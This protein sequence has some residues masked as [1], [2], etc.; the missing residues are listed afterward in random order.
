MATAGITTSLKKLMLNLLESS[1][2]SDQYYIAL[3]RS[4]SLDNLINTESSTLSEQRQ[5]RN[6]LHSVKVL[7]KSSMVVPTIEWQA[8]TAYTAFDDNN[9]ALTN[10]Y[11]VNSNREVFVCIQVSKNDDGTI[12]NSTIEPTSTLANN[13]ALSFSTSD[14]YVWRFIHAINIGVYSDFKNLN[15]LPLN[16]ILDEDLPTLPE[17]LTSVVLRDS[18]VGGEILSIAIDSGGQGYTTIPSITIQGNGAS[19]SF[20]ATLNNGSITKI[21]VDSDGSGNFLHGSAFDYVKVTPSYGDA[22]LRPVLGPKEGT[23]DDPR[24]TLLSN[25]VMFK[26]DFDNTEAS[27]IL[28]ENDFRTVAILKNVKTPA[29]TTYTGNTGNALNYFTLGSVQGGSTFNDDEFINS[30]VAS[31]KVFHWD[32]ANTLYY[33]QNDSTGYGTFTPGLGISS[34]SGG[35]AN[36]TTIN[37]PDIDRYSGEI[38]YINNF[39]EVTRDANQTED[40]RLVLTLD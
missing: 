10:F 35:Q 13:S 27:T 8:N 2:D 16:K 33:Y 22:V 17:D 28:A 18:S 25:T 37:Q 20:T 39:A 40:I 5:V 32:G 23:S 34:L 29:G 36:I 9:N 12:N 11:V 38:L 19:A 30:T 6:Q 14:G 3:A 4:N 24:D 26:M 1:V 15:Y 31:A 7:A 21:E